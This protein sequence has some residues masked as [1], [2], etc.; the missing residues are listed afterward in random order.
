MKKLIVLLALSLTSFAGV[1]PAHA[2]TGAGWRTGSF[3]DPLG[4]GRYRG[5]SLHPQYGSLH[6]WTKVFITCSDG[7]NKTGNAS[8]SG[9]QATSATCNNGAWITGYAPLYG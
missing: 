1:A 9:T 5:V 2:S 7:A 6:N 4:G 8:Y 3:F